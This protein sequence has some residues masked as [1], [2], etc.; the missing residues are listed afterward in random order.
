MLLLSINCIYKRRDGD[1]LVADQ[2]FDRWSSYYAR[3]G[4]SL[5]LRWHCTLPSQRSLLQRYHITYQGNTDIS[6]AK[7]SIVLTLS[8]ITT[9]AGIFLSSLKKL[10]FNYRLMAL[11]SICGI[12]GSTYSL[13]YM[14][15]LYTYIFFYGICFGMFIGYGYLASV[16]N[17]YDYLPNR[18]GNFGVR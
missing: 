18:K 6:A 12:S 17:C 9:N 3:Y 11:I 5:C 16:R 8:I 2:I 1:G 13:S 4:V 10:K 7:L 15:S 14:N